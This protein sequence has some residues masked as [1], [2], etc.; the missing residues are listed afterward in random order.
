MEGSSGKY[1]RHTWRSSWNRCA[2]ST[3]WTE[4]FRKRSPRSLFPDAV[5]V[6]RS[7][8]ENRGAE[9]EQRWSQDARPPRCHETLANA[10]GERLDQRL[11]QKPQHWSRKRSYLLG[12]YFRELNPGPHVFISDTG[13]V[14]AILFDIVVSS[15]HY[16]VS[17]FYRLLERESGS[18][19]PPQWSQQTATRAMEIVS[20]ARAALDFRGRIWKGTAT[21]R[22]TSLYLWY[23]YPFWSFTLDWPWE[24]GIICRRPV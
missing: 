7:H 16:S 1:K 3:S 17:G 14:T 6:S 18:V 10:N 21:L 19:R 5:L 20:V 9:A 22:L 11:S 12:G 23:E 8:M 15:W 24:T 2:G 4:V 13:E